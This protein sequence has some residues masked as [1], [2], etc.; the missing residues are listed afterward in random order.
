M[1]SDF[2]DFYR[3]L[4]VSPNAPLAEIKHAWHAKMLECH[5]DRHLGEEARYE[6][7]SREIN[8][9][10]AVL[11]NPRERA[12]FDVVR[13][14]YLRERVK[15]SAG[16]RKAAEKSAKKEAKKE[17]PEAEAATSAEPRRPWKWWERLCLTLLT[18][19]LAVYLL[20]LPPWEK[21]GP[22]LLAYLLS[23]K[24]A[25]ATPALPLF[26]AVLICA[27][28]VVACVFCGKIFR[29]RLVPLAGLS[30]FSFALA[31]A[32]TFIIPLKEHPEA[33]SFVIAPFALICVYRSF[34]RNARLVAGTAARVFAL[35]FCAVVYRAATLAFGAAEPLLAAGS[36]LLLC[37]F[38]AAW[39]CG[40][41]LG[42]SD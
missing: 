35:A 28:P 39:A 4:G 17:K 31:C 25:G 19:S 15:R 33:L 20:A 40:D 38:M 6:T 7:L 21:C 13:A 14:A 18:C 34:G 5:P 2:K 12:E 26:G 9:A 11:S 1:S 23:G 36:F 22:P 8:A 10:Y 37:A 42:K 3:I 24:S 32:A 16:A 29:E 41:F 27:V 30:V